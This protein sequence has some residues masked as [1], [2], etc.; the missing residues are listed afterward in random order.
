LGR[1]KPLVKLAFVKLTHKFSF[2]KR[3]LARVEEEEEEEEES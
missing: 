1:N 3:T 2:P